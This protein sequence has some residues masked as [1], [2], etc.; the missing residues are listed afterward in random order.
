MTSGYPPSEADRGRRGAARNE[1][2]ARRPFFCCESVCSRQRA[3][4]SLRCRA[5]PKSSHRPGRGY[6]PTCSRSPSRPGPH[7]AHDRSCGRPDCRGWHDVRTPNPAPNPVRSVVAY[8]SSYTRRCRPSRSRGRQHGRLSEMRSPP[9]V[10]GRGR[11][12]AERSEWSTRLCGLGPL[13]RVF[14][15][16]NRVKLLYRGLART[17]QP[18]TGRCIRGSV[19]EME[20]RRR[21]V[22]S[23]SSGRRRNSHGTQAADHSQDVPSKKNPASSLNQ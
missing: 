22:K 3:V 9:V 5:P 11:A 19:S 17:D 21:R 18:W 23:A 13:S 6:C 20:R 4:T 10:A 7:R 15:I 8:C 16:A 2:R 12:S 1:Q 14:G